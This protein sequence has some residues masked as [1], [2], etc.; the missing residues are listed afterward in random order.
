MDRAAYSPRPK[1]I[2]VELGR[3]ATPRTTVQPPAEHVLPLVRRAPELPR[4]E[5]RSGGIRG[6]LGRPLAE[7]PG[8]DCSRARRKRGASEG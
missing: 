4:G 2:E 8:R 3:P 6:G 1:K 7:A 5:I